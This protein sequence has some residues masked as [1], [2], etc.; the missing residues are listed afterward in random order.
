[1]RKGQSQAV[2]QAS[3][4][5]F[6]ERSE[7][8]RTVIFRGSVRDLRQSWYRQAERTVGELRRCMVRNRVEIDKKKNDIQLLFESSNLQRLQEW[9]EEMLKFSAA[10][11][12]G[13]LSGDIPSP[14]NP[15]CE[16]LIEL[17]AQLKHIIWQAKQ[18][19]AGD[20]SQEIKG[21]GEFAEVFNTIIG[22]M[23]ERDSQLTQEQ[24]EIKKQIETVHNYNE[25][26][27]EL[28]RKQNEWILV[29]DAESREIVYCNKRKEGQEEAEDPEFCDICEHR[30]PF[31]NKLIKWDEEDQDN[32]WEISDGAHRYYRITTFPLE[33]Q[34]RRA[35]AHILKDITDEKL[36]TSS[37]KDKAYHDALTGIYNRIYFEEYMEKTLRDKE[38][39]VLGYLDLDCLKNINDKY[40]H[41]AGDNYIRLFVHTIQKNFRNTDVF[42]RVGG[43][44]F[45]LILKT[46]EKE[47]VLEKLQT[48]MDEFRSYT[49]KKNVHGFSYGVVE[50]RGEEETRTLKEII[51]T[52]DAA[53]Y[54]CKRNNKEIYKKWREEDRI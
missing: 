34:N 36:R 35:N 25:L 39:I 16:N 46:T 47:V 42:A 49:D 53:M 48:A 22:Q 15:L 43:D 33:W 7:S 1:M 27:L 6:D 38:R 30:L 28:T 31:R 3:A 51:D 12:G 50:V 41:A 26:L 14:E 23:R 45:C 2:L 21:L 4:G 18:V 17:Q 37:L 9:V 52:A 13:E 29:V 24:E 54:E 10:V 44:E 20:Y 11:A 32:R 8:G 5:P 19:A 40:G